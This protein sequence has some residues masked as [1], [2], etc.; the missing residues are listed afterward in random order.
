MSHS[1]VRKHLNNVIMSVSKKHDYAN[2]CQASIL[3]LVSDFGSIFS[4]T[5]L[6]LAC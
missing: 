3:V 4:S 6:Q 2:C 5:L 1:N